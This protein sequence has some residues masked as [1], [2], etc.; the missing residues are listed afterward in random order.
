ML[1]AGCLLCGGRRPRH[2]PK[3]QPES[4]IRPLFDA[5]GKNQGRF[6]QNC[7]RCVPTRGLPKITD[8][9]HPSDLRISETPGTAATA[10]P[11]PT[12]CGATCAC[13]LAFRASIFSAADHVAR[14]WHCMQCFDGVARLGA[15][16]CLRMAGSRAIHLRAEHSV[17]VRAGN[18]AALLGLRN[19]A[20]HTQVHLILR[21][22][23]EP[24]R[25]RVFRALPGTASITASP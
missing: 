21:F 3:H 7:N 8:L 6:C 25:E 9:L 13:I 20:H 11:L 24:C 4:H 18:S 15:G 14:F 1:G 17:G 12:P 19:A 23:A 10:R 5:L 16:A 22:L 2:G